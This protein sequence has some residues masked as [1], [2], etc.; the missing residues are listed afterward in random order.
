M[1]DLARQGRRYILSEVA[2]EVG[3]DR[4]LTL[5][6]TGLEDGG[7]DLLYA[8][9]FLGCCFFGLAA[10]HEGQGGKEINNI[11]SHIRCYLNS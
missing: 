1:L 7:A 8:F 6:L 11:L 5:D 3:R 4:Y 9:L 10:R 2:L